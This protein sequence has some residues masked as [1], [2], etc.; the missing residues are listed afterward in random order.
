[1]NIQT[2]PFCGDKIKHKGSKGC[3]QK[4]QEH[5]TEKHLDDAF[6]IIVKYNPISVKEEIV[7][8]FIWRYNYFTEHHEYVEETE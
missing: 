1:M 7:K 4:L 3:V 8:E 6:N 5:I 2:C